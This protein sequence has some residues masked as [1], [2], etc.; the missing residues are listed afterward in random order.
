VFVLDRQVSHAT[1]ELLHRRGEHN[2][3]TL[4]AEVDVRD[5]AAC[6]AGVD[7]AVGHVDALVNAIG[8]VASAPLLDISPSGFD[9][10][11]DVNLRGTFS[12]RQA[13]LRHFADR[14]SGSIVKLPPSPPSAAAWWKAPTSRVLK[15]D[16]DSVKPPEL[17]RWS[18]SPASRSALCGDS[19]GWTS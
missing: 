3:P 15:F 6:A 14:R 4:Y 10:L 12:L 18:A 8:A 5:P 7:A 13:V 1:R 17:A 19:G 11:L 16:S 9:E 2:V